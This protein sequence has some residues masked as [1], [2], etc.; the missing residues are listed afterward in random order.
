MVIERRPK[1]L[2]LAVI[3]SGVASELFQTE[4]R[5]V[6]QRHLRGTLI[7]KVK[8]FSKRLTH[9]RKERS[10]LSTSEAKGTVC[11]S[12]L[13]GVSNPGFHRPIMTLS[14]SRCGIQTC[15]GLLSAP[16]GGRNRTGVTP[17]AARIASWVFSIF[18]SRRW[19]ARRR[20]SRVE[21]DP[22]C[23]QGRVGDRKWDFLGLPPF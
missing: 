20:A 4:L 3:E 18:Q 8:V 19:L 6:F 7:A 16:Y 21:G 1:L 2:F 13:P 23:D 12:L 11:R 9:D 22:M 14:L 15:S 17:H 5:K 10:A